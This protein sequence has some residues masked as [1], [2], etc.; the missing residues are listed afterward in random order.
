MGM[1]P[2]RK[3]R[4]ADYLRNWYTAHMKRF[5]IA[6][7]ILAAAAVSA[8]Q[9]SGWKVTKDP[10]GDSYS[11]YY[12]GER[13][14]SARDTGAGSYDVS[15]ASGEHLGTGTAASQTGDGSFAVGNVQK[16]SNGQY[17]VFDQ[18][19]QHRWTVDPAATP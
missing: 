9:E 16:N 11:V 4:I 3:T 2:S 18:A 10:T 14:G 12:N 6:L 7:I 13:M 17:E 1:G 8:Q 5:A 19:G 15:N